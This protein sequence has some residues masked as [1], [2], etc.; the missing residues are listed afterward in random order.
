MLKKNQS[1]FQSVAIPKTLAIFC[2]HMLSTTALV[3]SLVFVELCLI[4]DRGQKHF[5][6][7]SQKLGCSC[8]KNV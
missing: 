6:R 4:G 3:D 2:A 7:V 1:N 8:A 5:V